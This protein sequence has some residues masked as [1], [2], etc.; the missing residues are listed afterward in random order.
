M[1]RNCVSTPFSTRKRLYES[2]LWGRQRWSLPAW[3]NGQYQTFRIKEQTV[4]LF[5]CFGGGFFWW[6]GLFW[7]FFGEGGRFVTFCLFVF[8]IYI[9]S[10][11]SLWYLPIP[12]LKNLYAPTYS[13]KRLK[14]APLLLQWR[15]VHFFYLREKSTALIMALKHNDF[16]SLKVVCLIYRDWS[17][18]QQ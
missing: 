4:L 6:W 14:K 1:L 5:C 11:P 13:R 3:Q 7:F 10:L 16:L 12:Y 9:I 2:E 17:W 15:K 18:K 8:L